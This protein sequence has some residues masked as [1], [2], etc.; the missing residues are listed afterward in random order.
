MRLVTPVTVRPVF[1]PMKTFSLELTTDQLRYIAANAAGSLESVTP[2][3]ASC[4]DYTTLIAKWRAFSPCFIERRL[5]R[6]KAANFEQLEV[7]R[8]WLDGEAD[9][10]EKIA[11]VY[12]EAIGA[13]VIRA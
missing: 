8:R 12:D 6:R 10:L 5:T 2:G 1:Y 4:E 7:L 9:F 11:S 13:E 3:S